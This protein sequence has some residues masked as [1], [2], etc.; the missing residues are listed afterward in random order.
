MA[1][2]LELTTKLSWLETL[3]RGNSS[4]VCING[5]ALVAAACYLLVSS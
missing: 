2:K 1:P 5:S 4:Q 3:E